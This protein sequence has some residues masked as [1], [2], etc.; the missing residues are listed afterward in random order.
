MLGTLAA[1]AITLSHGIL[2]PWLTPVV[3][4]LLLMTSGLLRK[5]DAGLVT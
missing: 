1:I 4:T 2:F 5:R 3:T